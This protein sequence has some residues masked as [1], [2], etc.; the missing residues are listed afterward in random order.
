MGCLDREIRAGRPWKLGGITTWRDWI[1]GH[2]R[3][4]PDLEMREVITH[5]LIF[6]YKGLVQ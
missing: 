6:A 3:Q 4:S 2:I 5:C 1:A